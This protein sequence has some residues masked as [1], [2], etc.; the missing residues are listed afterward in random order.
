MGVFFF[1][2][3]EQYD[4]VQKV[5]FDRVDLPTLDGRQRVLEQRDLFLDVQRPE[6]GPV[7]LM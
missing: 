7:F 5:L 4:L 1:T 3:F 2:W 6:T